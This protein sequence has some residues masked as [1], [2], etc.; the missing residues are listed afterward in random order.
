MHLAVFHDG[1][2]AEVRVLAV[3]RKADHRLRFEVHLKAVLTE[4][5]AHHR[6][7]NKFIVRRLQGVGKA[8]VDLDLLA[9]MR[10]LARLIDLRL[11]AADLLVSHLDLQAI[12]I[13]QH[14]RLL[15]RR[16]HS[17]VRALPILFLHDLGRGKLLDVRLFE[18]RLD[19]ELQLRR[20]GELE[21]SN[22]RAVDMLKTRNM[23]MLF[24]N[25]HELFFQ[26]DQGVLQDGARV[27]PLAVMNEK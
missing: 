9:H 6:A 3:A 7:H 17:A 20:R 8:P 26:I 15:Q 25:L 16:A 12:A 10:H 19:P 27:N 23:R 22:L 4:D 21:I 11:E 24:E 1:G 5:L 14:D 13:E 2:D 18:R